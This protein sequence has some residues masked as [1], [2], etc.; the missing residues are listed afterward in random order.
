M[1]FLEHA[2]RQVTADG[3][4]IVEKDLQ[5]V[6]R[7]E[8]IEQRLYRDTRARKNRCSAV[9]VEVDCNEMTLHTR[10]LRRRTE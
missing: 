1:R 4:K 9:D 8:V 3:W 2:Y 7:F 6:T 5:R 10:A